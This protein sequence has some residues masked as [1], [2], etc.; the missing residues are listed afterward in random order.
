MEK[1][2]GT[3]QRPRDHPYFYLILLQI[4]LIYTNLV[5]LQPSLGRDT[6]P[7]SP[8]QGGTDIFTQHRWPGALLGALGES[9]LAQLGLAPKFRRKIKPL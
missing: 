7:R 3:E 9:P 6:E 5:P 1:G 2:A 4:Y 8:W